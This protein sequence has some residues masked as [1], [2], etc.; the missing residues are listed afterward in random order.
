MHT[1]I[2]RLWL[3]GRRSPL[4]ASLAVMVLASLVL[5]GLLVAD[6]LREP[7]RAQIALAQ[8]QAETVHLRLKQLSQA[9]GAAAEAP[10]SAN[11]WGNEI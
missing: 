7:R 3:W 4:G 2:Q 10:G 11:F 6:R 1:P 9:V 5:G 8:Q